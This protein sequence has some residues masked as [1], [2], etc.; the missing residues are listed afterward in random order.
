MW[1][2]I[3]CL[4]LLVSLL[5]GQGTPASAQSVPLDVNVSQ[6]AA[7]DD[8]ANAAA[9]GA[10]MQSGLSRQPIARGRRACCSRDGA[11][12]GAAIGAGIGALFS[13][14][15]DAGDCTSTYLRNI[16]VLGGV[17][18]AIGAF[19]DHRPLHPWPS[20]RVAVSVLAV[21]KALRA[22]ARITF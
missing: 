20:R 16:A 5:L 7:I 9:V 15:C 4:C 3:A 2:G 21:P 19:T 14:A 1:N 18:G 10:A 6:P 12:I 13:L 11:I 8:Q 22:A 17:G